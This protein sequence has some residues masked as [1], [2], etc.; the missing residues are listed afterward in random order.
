MRPEQFYH[1][2]YMSLVDYNDG[3]ID[4]V[5]RGNL[6]LQDPHRRRRGHVPGRGRGV[7]GLRLN[8]HGVVVYGHNR[9]EPVHDIGEHQQYLKQLVLFIFFS[10]GQQ[11][12]LKLIN[13]DDSTGSTTAK[14][15]SSST[16]TSTTGSNAQTNATSASNGLGSTAI[17]GIVVGCILGVIVLS[18]AG[19]LFS[20]YQQQERRRRRDAANSLFSD[21]LVLRSTSAGGATAATQKSLPPPPPPG[22]S[23]PRPPPAAVMP[24]AAAAG[25]YAQHATYEQQAAAYAYDPAVASAAYGYAGVDGGAAATSQFPGYYDEAGHYH[26]YDPVQDQAYQAQLAAAARTTTTTTVASGISHPS[27]SLPSRPPSPIAKEA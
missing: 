1:V 8:M 16:A 3:E 9:I 23:L 24:A 27:A 7:P 18:A 14:S 20:R 19:L 17:A 21:D 26:F 12:H 25:A 13:D 2:G 22:A 4:Q 10:Q 11:Q 15:S 6:H 5:L